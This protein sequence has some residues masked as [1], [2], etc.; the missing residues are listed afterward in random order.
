[1]AGI[2]HTKLIQ[3]RVDDL[4]HA[5]SIFGKK[6]PDGTLPLVLVPTK[7]FFFNW[8]M[9]I[10]DGVHLVIHKFGQDVSDKFGPGLHILPPWYQVAFLI[11]KQSCIYDAPVKNCYTKDNVRVQCDVTLVFRVTDGRKFVYDL[12]VLKF[13][14]LLN[15]A[16]EEAIRSLVRNIT[17][18]RIYELRGSRALGFLQDLNSTFEKFG[19]SFTDA[20]ITNVLLPYELAFVFERETT[21]GTKQLE[22][23]KRHE[24][25]LKLQADNAELAMQ[26][27]V[28]QER[29]LEADELAR[30]DRANIQNEQAEIT[31]LKDKQ[32]AIIAAEESAS[33]AKFRAESELT[34]SKLQGQQSATS[35]LLIAK[36]E[37][38]AKRINAD[39]EAEVEEIRTRAEI[40]ASK[41]RSQAITLEAN[42]E[43]KAATQMKD[44]RAHELEMERLSAMEHLAQSGHIVVS[45]QVGD[46][47][48]EMITSPPS[49]PL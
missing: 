1:M 5:V 17:H 3:I 35:S 22:Q 24:Y 26:Q 11:S 12:N 27:L 18:D 9:I 13:D 25:N 33:V 4:S 45:G 41:N 20:T 23:Q 21:I 16:T 31:A 15:A 48:L 10:P 44:K 34:N 40:E 19:V 7:R 49:L 38:D 47:V 42:A 32:L 8:W 30:K 39:Q 36:G 43:A 2:I 28:A 37:A 29:R 6:Q 46:R 14:E